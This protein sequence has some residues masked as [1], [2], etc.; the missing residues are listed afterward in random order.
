MIV[1]YTLEKKLL[2]INLKKKDI[3][4]F[5]ATIC[6]EEACN[7]YITPSCVL[8]PPWVATNSTII[9]KILDHS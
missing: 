4:Q 9:D 7:L 6:D 3:L 5:S 2:K 8:Q 1:P